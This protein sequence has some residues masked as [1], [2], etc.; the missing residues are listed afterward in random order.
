MLSKYEAGR[1]SSR[2]SHLEYKFSRMA[3]SSLV[4]HN[5]SGHNQSV[6]TDT[7]DIPSSKIGNVKKSI[8]NIP[9]SKT[10]N[11][12]E[13]SQTTNFKT[14]KLDS[15]IEKQL[16]NNKTVLFT[17]KNA[18]SNKNYFNV[19]QTTTEWGKLR[20]KDCYW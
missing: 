19:Q 10:K 9:E 3:A 17:P 11:L 14:L 16:L 20:Y 8:K 7:I 13:R 2:M 5:Y 12:S 6:N 18:N 1:K 15:Q 4:Y